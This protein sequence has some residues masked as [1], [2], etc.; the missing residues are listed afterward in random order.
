MRSVGGSIVLAGLV[1]GS[2][3]IGTAGAAA[4]CGC[5]AETVA[6]AV[7]RADSVYVAR[8]RWVDLYPGA[9][10]RVLRVLKGKPRSNLRIPANTAEC[11]T[12]VPRVVHVIRSDPEFGSLPL[13]LCTEYLRGAAAVREAEH[14]LGPGRPVPRR[15][16]PAWLAQWPP[17]LFGAGYLMWRH[18]KKRRARAV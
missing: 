8:P 14:V 6:S 16:D 15:P 9:S 5:A 10:F 3:V 7:T 11:G 1:A 17:L 13:N 12:R 2:V 4:S 18:T